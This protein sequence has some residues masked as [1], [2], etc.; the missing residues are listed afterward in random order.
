MSP[1]TFILLPGA[2]HSSIFWQ[3]VIPLLEEQGHRAIAPELLGVGRDHTPLSEVGLKS[4]IDQVVDIINQQQQGKVILVGHSRSGVIISEV[5]QRIPEKVQLLVYLTAFLVPSGETLSDATKK[6]PRSS[7]VTVAHLDG[8]LTLKPDQVISTFYNT[9]PSEW[10]EKVPDL[11]S[12]EPARIY[13]TA[14]HLT[15]DRFGIVPR[16]YIECAQDKIIPLDFQRSMQKRLPC[17]YVAT[18]NTDHSPFFSAPIELATH[19]IDL[20]GRA[21]GQS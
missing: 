1:S 11:L 16:A 5:A 8:T 18:M 17:Q 14:L 10:A 12:A 19:L 4:W 7:E 2:W 6:I 20:A 3:R 9:T 21:D 15:E 13:G